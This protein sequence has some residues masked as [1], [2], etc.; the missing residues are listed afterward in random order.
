LLAL[1]LLLVCGRR[2]DP[3]IAAVVPMALSQ[4]MC[5]ITLAQVVAHSCSTHWAAC[6]CREP[7]ANA[8]RIR[9]IRTADFR[10]A[11]WTVAMGTMRLLFVC[12]AEALLTAVK[13][14]ITNWPEFAAANNIS[15]WGGN[16]AIPPCL[17]TG[18]TCDADGQ[19]QAL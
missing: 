12:S 16:P 8:G 15:G 5:W 18:V 1:L 7:P 9:H 6:C 10:F 11:S 4:R 3:V 17:Y 2:L 14:H 19:L 13:Q